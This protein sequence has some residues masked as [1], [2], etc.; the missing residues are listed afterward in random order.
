M[1]SQDARAVPQP[2]ATFKPPWAMPAPL[3]S[4]HGSCPEG[5]W[6]TRIHQHAEKFTKS[7]ANA[8]ARGQRLPRWPALKTPGQEDGLFSGC[9]Q[10][11]RRAR[12][13]SAPSVPSGEPADQRVRGGPPTAPTHA[14]PLIK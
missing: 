8:L 3:L 12:R 13:L 1:Q 10:F 9:G 2:R 5:T 7:G 14:G 11:S 4:K 6:E